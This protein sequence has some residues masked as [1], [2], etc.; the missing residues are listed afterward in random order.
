MFGI[1]GSAVEDNGKGGLCP[2]STTPRDAITLGARA[3]F[4]DAA[5]LVDHL[6]G[7]G[8]LVDGA[9]TRAGQELVARVQARIATEAAPIWDGPAAADVEAVTRLLNEVTQRARAVLRQDG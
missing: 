1:A 4:A 9:P 6:T 3:Q 5:D 7:Q 8:L 2:T